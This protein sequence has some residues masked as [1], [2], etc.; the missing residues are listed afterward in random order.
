ME[1]LTGNE[2]VRPPT[3]IKQMTMREAQVR[4]KGLRPSRSTRKKDVQTPTTSTSLGGSVSVQISEEKE[5]GLTGRR[6]SR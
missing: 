2:R 5:I 1:L 3:I 4:S 6:R